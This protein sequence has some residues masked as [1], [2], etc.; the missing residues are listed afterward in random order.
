M[1]SAF[2]HNTR[3]ILSDSPTLTYDAPTYPGLHGFTGT[4]ALQYPTSSMPAEYLSMHSKE[5]IFAT[6][7]SAMTPLIPAE[8]CIACYPRRD[9]PDYHYSLGP[10]MISARSP[11][12]EQY[13]V[14]LARKYSMESADSA[15]LSSVKEVRRLLGFQHNSDLPDMWCKY[16][17]ALAGLATYP[18]PSHP[19][20]AALWGPA[21]RDR[22]A[23]IIHEI[24][25]YNPP[26][27]D[28][29]VAYLRREISPPDVPPAHRAQIITMPRHREAAAADAATNIAPSDSD[30]DSDE[31]P[32]KRARFVHIARQG[33]DPNKVFDALVMS[34]S[35]PKLEPT[36][37]LTRQAA[38][39]AAIVPELPTYRGQSPEDSSTRSS[40]AVSCE[41]EETALDTIATTRCRKRKERD[42]DD[43]RDEG[44]GEREDETDALPAD[45]PRKTS[46]ESK[47]A[48]STS[49]AKGP[50]R[51]QGS[52]NA[53]RVSITRMRKSRK[54]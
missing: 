21:V 52:I 45:R 3:P 22:T 40:T 34:R 50:T 14:A 38:R 13:L 4:A 39:L 15:R 27:F 10:G 6:P 28:G 18:D 29:S 24:Y 11:D 47:R 19:A 49:A 1:S 9:F 43:V 46:W 41:S 42:G 8:H 25:G 23:A 44:S 7:T 16:I 54:A 20:H 51:S 53:A 5:P 33:A 48:T 12:I 36:R 35:K 2:Y 37:R 17:I 32:R 30:S 26:L 31:P